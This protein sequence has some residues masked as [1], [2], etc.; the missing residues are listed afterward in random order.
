[1]Y[2]SNTESISFEWNEAKESRNR[3]KHGVSFEEACSSFYDAYARVIPDV[4]H[5]F[6]EERYV[7]LGLS[8][9]ARLLVVCHVLR[10]FGN[11]IRIISARVA[12]SREEETYRRYRHEG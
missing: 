12:T 1:M 8:T 10:G 9:Q 3:V 4:E 6:E 2:N 11:V 5:S 7:L